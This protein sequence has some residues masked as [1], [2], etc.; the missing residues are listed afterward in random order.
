MPDTQPSPA[1]ANPET[2]ADLREPTVRELLE[3]PLTMLIM[4]RD[5]IE[6][7][8]L[9]AL[10]ERERARLRLALERAQI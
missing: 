9:E 6:R 5:R 4:K 10:L 2:A 8:Q 7:A 3:D 1:T